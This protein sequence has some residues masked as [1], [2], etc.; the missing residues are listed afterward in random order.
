[1]VGLPM[2]LL[3]LT[4]N[5]YRLTRHIT[6]HRLLHKGAKTTRGIVAGCAA[7]TIELKAYMY[8]ALSGV[9]F[10]TPDANLE[11]YIDDLTVEAQAMNEDQLVEVLG[12]T[13][14]DLKETI[15]DDLGLETST[16]KTAIVTSISKTSARVEKFTGLLGA[17]KYQTGNPR[18]DLTSGKK[19]R[20]NFKGTSLSVRTQRLG[21]AKKRMPRVKRILKTK[22]RGLRIWLSGLVPGT[23]FGAESLESAPPTCSGSE[24]RPHRYCLEAGKAPIK[25]PSSPA[26]PRRTLRVVR[27][28][29][30]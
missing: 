10:R 18:I 7:A 22:G 13:A 6:H 27:L 12:N 3:R 23:T 29:R 16:K 5:S 2:H 1:M 24:E 9:I 4:I 19:I 17:T 25:A 21:K 30:A 11:V 28:C 8:T 15:E 26:I 14:I 20:D